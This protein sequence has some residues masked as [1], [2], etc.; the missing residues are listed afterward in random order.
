MERSIKVNLSSITQVTEALRIP[1]L[2]DFEKSLSLTWI[3]LSH[4]IFLDNLAP[5]LVSSSTLVVDQ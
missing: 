1:I 5:I 3:L 2:H 4:H